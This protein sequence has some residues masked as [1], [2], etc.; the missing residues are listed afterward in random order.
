MK[1]FLLPLFTL[2]ALTSGAQEAGKTPDTNARKGWT[3]GILP[4]IAYD[5]DLG[6]KY[7]ALTNLYYFGD[8]STYPDYLHSIYAE[9]SYATGKSGIFRLSYDSRYLVPNHRISVDLTYMPDALCDFYGF[10]GFA[11]PYY[12]NWTDESSDEYRTRAFYKMQRDLFRFSADMQGNMGGDWHWN[13]GVGVLNY[14]VGSVDIARLN[15]NKKPEE[16]LPDTTTLYDFYTKIY[17][18]CI[19]ENEATGGTHPYVHAGVTYDTRDR[20]QN[21]RRG[22][23][24]DAF[25]TYYAAFGNQSEY[26]HLRFNAAWRHYVPLGSERFTLAYRA[27]TQLLLAGNSSFYL[28]TYMNQLYMQRALYEG[29]GGAN[30]VRGIMRNRLLGDGFTYANVELRWLIK[31]F[32]IG[33]ENF[34]LGINPFADYGQLVQKRKLYNNGEVPS[35]WNDPHFSAGCGLKIAMN[36]NFVLSVDWAHALDKQ[37]NGKFSNLYVNIGYMF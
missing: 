9:A 24:A 36:D 7:G 30:S 33:K 29:L 25:L 11:Q 4:S 3:L 8:G 21:S 15:R 27:G 13:V 2:A 32:K 37:D 10:N 18:G 35:V 19:K 17:T 22:V 14:K 31:R 6:F 20:Q 12:A 23:H 34:Y 16:A 28:N 5:A 26:N 1:R